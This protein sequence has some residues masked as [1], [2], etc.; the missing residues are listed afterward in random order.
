[1]STPAFGRPAPRLVDHGGMRRHPYLTEPPVA[2]AHRGGYIWASEHGSDELAQ[3][4][5]NTMAA[6]TAAVALGYRYLETDAHATSDGVLISF[7]DD[8]LDRVTN[9]VGLIRS[10]PH[11][12]LGEARIG[13]EHPIPTLEELFTAFDTREDGAGLSSVRF[14]VDLESNGA[15]LPMLRLVECLRI[16]D[17]VCVAS[18]SSPRLWAFR[19]LSKLRRGPAAATSAGPLGVGALRLLPDV[20]T[21]WVHSPGIA[22]QVPEYTEIAG[23]P[24]RVVTPAFVRRAHALGKHVH[25]WTV[26]TEPEMRTL[27][28]MGVDGIVTDRID[29]LQRVL[30]TN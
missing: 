29:V 11:T 17:R 19:A 21:R 12:Q 28:A 13:G 18:F 8:R 22:Y 2:I 27:L 1:M 20:L 24:F 23:R 4:Q 6:F 3:Q 14:N 26:N 25:V 30:A 5:E 15:V 7:H 10:L 16:G 9:R